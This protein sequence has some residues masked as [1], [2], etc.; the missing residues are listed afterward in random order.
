MGKL[1]DGKV[2]IVTSGGKGLGR[3]FCFGMAEEGG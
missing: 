3:T 2:A 1:L